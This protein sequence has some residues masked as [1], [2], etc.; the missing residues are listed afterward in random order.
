M[1]ATRL[2]TV[3]RA[4]Y[5]L[6]AD[7]ADR[8]RHAGDRES[9][10]GTDLRV[11]FDVYLARAYG[12]AWLSAVAAVTVA[13]VAVLALPAST[14]RVG[15]ALLSS[16]VPVTVPPPFGHVER[17]VA[18]VAVAVPVGWTARS[19]V[20]RLAGSYLG[21]NARSRRGDIERTLPSAVRYLHALSSGSDGPRAMLRKVAANDAY[22]ATAVS[23][24]KA[25]NTASLAGGLGT[26]LGQVARDTPSRDLLA[27]FLLKFHEHAQQGEDELANYL[28][29]EARM[30]GHR[31]ERAR[32]RATDFLELVAELFVVLL[33]LPALLVVVLTVLAVLAPGLSEPVRTPLGA[34]TVRNVA[35]YGSAL[36]ALVVG[37]GASALVAELRPTAQQVSYRRPAGIAATLAT[38]AR[39]PASAAVVAVGPAVVAGGL[40]LTVGSRLADAVL[41]A[42]VVYAVPVGVAGLRRA[43]LDG[44]KDRQ[45][46]DFV[47]AVSGHVS[48]GRPFPRAVSLVAEEVD[49]GA[50]DADVADLA[51][52]LGL[53][54]G[55]GGDTSDGAG[56]VS[57][58]PSLGRNSSGDDTDEATDRRT[59]AL[60]RFVDQVGTPLAEQTMGLVTGALD[61][62]SDAETVFETL[63]VEIARLHH[64]KR[65]LRSNLLVYVAV[66]WTTALLV[67]GITVAVDRY[68]LDGFAQLAA[69]KGAAGFAL[70]PEAVQP[71]RDRFRLYVV[72]QATAVASGLFAGTASRGRYEALLH[73]A[74]LA[75]ACRTVYAGVAPL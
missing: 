16:L 29:M 31:R 53:G 20:V 21:W 62:G 15:A 45:I 9:Y 47:H 38:A 30:L 41:A 74:L 18:A 36:F 75:L 54:T 8:R 58:S 37:V 56:R 5:A 33:V 40:T 35:V 57:E 32:Q 67:V 51:F 63:Q 4:L 61:A 71:A 50:L 52:T 22:G 70:N 65:A 3:D 14:L 7:N 1:D 42:Y 26:G 46:K 60:E 55:V 66:G 12:V 24:R 43:R 11:S 44:A 23:I 10:R 49:L 6:F 59:A 73:S 48:L 25:L 39:N 68:V 2:S 27:P 34:T 17:T 19:L 72:A 69:V 28:Q 64:Q 13:L